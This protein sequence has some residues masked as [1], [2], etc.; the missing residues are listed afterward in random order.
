MSKCADCGAELT[1]ADKNEAGH[2]RDRCMDC[3]RATVRAMRLDR[4]GWS[5]SNTQVYR[6]EATD[7]EQGYR[8]A[9]EPASD[10]DLYGYGADD[11][12]AVARYISACSD[13]IELV[14][15]DACDDAGG[16]TA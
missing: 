10:G 15:H 13:R 5:Q 2:Y 4:G 11:L 3:I 1:D 7:A 8:R 9:T 6:I 16:E 14:V 12:E